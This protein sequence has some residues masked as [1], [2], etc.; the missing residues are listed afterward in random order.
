MQDQ[1]S[2]TRAELYRLLLDE[3]A[4]V[5]CNLVPRMLADPESLTPETRWCI[6]Y[7]VRGIGYL[8]SRNGLL[9][10]GSVLD[11]VVEGFELARLRPLLFPVVK[12]SSAVDAGR[13]LLPVSHLAGRSVRSPPRLALLAFLTLFAFLTF[14]GDN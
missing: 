4:G 9:G 13:A 2:H 14:T 1:K 7:L 12:G 6:L 8:A 5:A 11:T 3:Q 10:S